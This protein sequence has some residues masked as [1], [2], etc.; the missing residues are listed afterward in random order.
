MCQPVPKWGYKTFNGKRCWIHSDRLESTNNTPKLIEVERNV[1]NLLEDNK[2]AEAYT[3][4]INS[5]L[6]EPQQH[7]LIYKHF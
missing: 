7:F 2:R 1:L 5:G 6:P 3:H 4:I